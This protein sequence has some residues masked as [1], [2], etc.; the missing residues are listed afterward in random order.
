M[1]AFMWNGYPHSICSASA[2]RIPRK[3]E[4]EKEEERSPTVHLPYVAG[5]SERIRKLVAIRTSKYIRLVFNSGST[6]CSFLNKV[7]DPFPTEQ[8]N[9]IYE[10]PYICRKVCI[11]E[12]KHRLETHLKEACTKGSVDNLPQLNM[13]GQKT[14]L[15]TGMT[16]GLQCTASTMELVMKGA[17]CIQRAPESLH[18]PHNSGY[19]IP[20]CWI[21]KYKKIRGEVRVGCVHPSHLQ[22]KLY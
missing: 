19:D 11:G 14:I 7:Q 3:E 6:F 4:V 1:K 20:D 17:I 5:I 22:H 8:A 15:S 21:T 12:I 18:S 16:L 13:D 9:F 2:A 10:V